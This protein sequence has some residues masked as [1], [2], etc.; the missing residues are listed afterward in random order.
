[1]A[2]VFRVSRFAFRVSR[3]AFRVSR[4]PIVLRFFRVCLA[5]RDRSMRAGCVAGKIVIRI[6][7]SQSLPA[8]FF[9][10]VFLR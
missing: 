1:M 4:S 6:C 5:L 3:F 8:R 7:A 9:N 2:G 10:A